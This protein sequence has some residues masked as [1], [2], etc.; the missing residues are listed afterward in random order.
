M[1]DASACTAQTR[2]HLWASLDSWAQVS[3]TLVLTPKWNQQGCL[4][5]IL[6]RWIDSANFYIQTCFLKRVVSAS[7]KRWQNKGLLY[8]SE[9][10]RAVIF[11][12]KHELYLGI[13]IIRGS[14]V[15]KCIIS[16]FTNSAID[17]VK[18]MIPSLRILSEEWNP[19]PMSLNH[20]WIIAIKCI[21]K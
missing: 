12:E 1:W 5:N 10:W 13:F 9:I 11:N 2:W 6:R 16:V 15:C 19:F 4:K 20:H 8:S 17:M 14:W 21:L 18:G 7:L 3:L